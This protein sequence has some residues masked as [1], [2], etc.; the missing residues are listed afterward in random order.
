VFAQPKARYEIA[1]VRASPDRD[2][3]R[4]FVAR[5]TGPRGRRLM[6]DAGFRF[7]APPKPAR[8]RRA[9]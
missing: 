1:V 3:A 2:A 8:G 7:P 6:A 9:R 4:A 5:A